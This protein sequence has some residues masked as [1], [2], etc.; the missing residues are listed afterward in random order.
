MKRS[1]AIAAF[2][3]MA[4]VVIPA[5]ARFMRAE[6]ETVPVARLVTNLEKEIAASP[7]NAALHSTLARLYSMAYALKTNQFEATK[8]D[9]KPFF[10]YVNT[11]HP[12]SQVRKVDSAPLETEA[13]N[14]LQQ[15]I[16]EYEKALAID[17]NH[18]ASRLGLGW[19]LDQAGDKT[20]ALTHYRKALSQAWEKEQ[21]GAT[22]LNTPMTAETVDYMLPLLDPTKDAEEIARIKQYKAAV[23][24]HP[25]AVTPILIPLQANVPLSELINPN[26][27][28]TFDLDGSGLPS[29]WGWIT[30]NAAWLVYH[31]DKRQSITSGLQLFGNVTFWA[32]W[33]NGYDALSAL[34]DNGDGELRGQELEHLALWHDANSNGI[35]EPCEVQPLSVWNIIALSCHGQRHPTGIPFHPTGVQFKDGSSLPSYDWISPSGTHNRAEGE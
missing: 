20:N 26:A 30:P 8:R 27:A 33:E 34:D 10:G 31:P 32:F 12:P 3:L 19:C 35:S 25:R 22:G 21:K 2:T 17:P 28:V 9:N 15:A 4:L 23:L 13:T 5:R 24:R 16:Q 11:D 7:T 29:Q 1:H 6:T 18:L 14:H